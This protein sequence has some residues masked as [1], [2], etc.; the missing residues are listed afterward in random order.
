MAKQ[1]LFNKEV[2]VITFRVAQNKSTKRYKSFNVNEEMKDRAKANGVD[3]FAPNTNGS[4]YVPLTEELA[5]SESLYVMVSSE[6][7]KG[8]VDPTVKSKKKSE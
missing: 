5:K 3:L 8:W 1:V 4:I 7:P 6:P 2:E